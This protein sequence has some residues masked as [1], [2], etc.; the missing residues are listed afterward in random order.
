MGECAENEAE[1]ANRARVPS[2]GVRRALLDC[3]IQGRRAKA[4]ESHDGDLGRLHQ[5]D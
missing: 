3:R 4:V 5:R 1:A 2:C